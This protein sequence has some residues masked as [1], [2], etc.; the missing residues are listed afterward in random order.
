MGKERKE[1]ARGAIKVVCMECGKKFSVGP[2][3]VCPECPKCGGVDV[4]VR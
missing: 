2:G 4:E 3:A 1:M